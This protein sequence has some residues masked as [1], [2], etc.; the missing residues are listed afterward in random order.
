L[1]RG[2]GRFFLHSLHSLIQRPERLA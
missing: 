1:T 2:V